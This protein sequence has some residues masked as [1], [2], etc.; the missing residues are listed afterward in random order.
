V[1]RYRLF[2][3]LLLVVALMYGSPY[4]ALLLNRVMGPWSADAVEHDGS[5]THMVFDANLP[6]AD[7]IPVFPGASVVQSSR[8]VSEY[9]PS[10]FNSLELAVH[11]SAATVRDFYRAR[12]EAEGFVVDD[13]GTQGLNTAAAAY[14]GVA[15]TLTAKRARTDDTVVV[16]IRTDEGLIVRT[17][18]VQISWR[19][20]SEWPK[21][22]AQ[23]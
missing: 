11:G 10:G 17:R 2:L 3:L 7:F 16:Q 20:L 4:A 1:R 13:L 5:V 18:L 19:K 14:L 22:Q 8:L 15:G 21:G 23:P 6:P 12:L 9:A